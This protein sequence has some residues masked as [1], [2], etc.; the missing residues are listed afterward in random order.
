M[1]YEATRLTRRVGSASRRV[2]SDTLRQPRTC[3]H[4]TSA[5]GHPPRRRAASGTASG[6]A[7][8][9]Y[10]TS[11]I[12][13]VARRTRASVLWRGGCTLNGLSLMSQ[14]INGYTGSVTEVVAATTWKPVS[15]YSSAL[16]IVKISY[17]R[18][19]VVSVPFG[20]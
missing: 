20:N 10:P 9:R 11:G 18:Q 16:S 14:Q 13:V 5:A 15:T 6:R 17:S 7:P 19:P 3:R 8:I 2:W 1:A 4:S 12:S